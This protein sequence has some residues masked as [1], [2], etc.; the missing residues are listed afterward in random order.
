MLVQP[1]VGVRTYSDG[2]IAERD[3]FAIC[4]LSTAGAIDLKSVAVMA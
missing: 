1:L 3:G 2:W 4:A